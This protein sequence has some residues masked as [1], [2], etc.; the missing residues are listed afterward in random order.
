MKKISTLID[1]VLLICTKKIAGTLYRLIGVTNFD[2]ARTLVYVCI[3]VRLCSF[4]ISKKERSFLWSGIS[5]GLEILVMITCISL[6]FLINKTEKQVSLGFANRNRFVFEKP[7][8]VFLLFFPLSLF[9]LQ[10]YLR[11]FAS[12][13]VLTLED[14][15]I[16]GKNVIST[17]ILLLILYF[18]SIEPEPP[19]ES[20]LKKLFGKIKEMCNP[21]PIAQPV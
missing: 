8:K 19:S 14:V 2:I 13:R 4:I 1:C 18:S 16:L 21:D 10:L 9:I 7:R 5:T 20:K 3:I 11:E 17:N 15:G 6:Y 12:G